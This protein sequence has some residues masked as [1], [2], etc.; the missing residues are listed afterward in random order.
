MAPERRLAFG[1]VAELYHQHRPAY[2]ERLVDDLVDLV[3]LDGVQAVLEVGAGTGK[4]TAMFAARGIPVLAVEPSEEMAGVAR[5]TFAADAK[6]RIERSDFET[7]DPAG[8]RF[9][10]VFSAQAWHWVQQPAGYAKAAAALARGGLLAAFWNRPH[11]AR[12]ELRD[13]LLA[14]Y[15]QTAPEL[16]ALDG[17]LHPGRP[18]PQAEENWEE[19]IAAADGLT[20]ARVRHYEWKE[21]Y[22]A[23]AYVSLLN[24]HSAIRV[25][26][27]DR[28]TA[29]LTAVAETIT[30][31]GG[32]LTLPLVT[33]VC[34]ALKRE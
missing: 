10:L 32:R 3:G 5:R 22:S 15:E 23:D 33:R 16:A 8:R 1:E 13:A 17:S 34:T 24:T 6:V 11:W 19:A 26:D 4:A 25:L 28:R 31:H 30:D 12:S 21:D 2:P 18:Y 14:T 29:L 9:P 20:G 27:E 7:W